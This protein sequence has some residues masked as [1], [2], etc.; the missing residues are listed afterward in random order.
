MDDKVVIIGAGPSGNHAAYLLARK[1]FKVS[2]YENHNSIGR[3]IQ[4]TGILT[5]TIYDVYDVP[6]EVIVN[7]AKS[8]R[9]FSPSGKTVDIKL[10]GDIIVDRHLFDKSIADKAKDAG[11]EFFLDSTFI[12]TAYDSGSKVSK[13]NSNFAV[14][15]TK[16]RKIDA[17]IK[18]PYNY[19]IGADGPNSAVAKSAG[20]FQNRESRR[21]FAGIQ[22]TIKVDSDPSIIEF[23]PYIGQLG[24]I[25]PESPSI[26]R[27]GIAA[28]ASA[29]D[30]KTVYDPR[31]IFED[32]CKSRIGTDWKSKIVEWQSGPIPVYDPKIMIE[33]NNIFTIGDAA[34]QVKATTA[35][36]IIQGMNA[37]ECVSRS[38]ENNE[39][40]TSL[41]NKKIGRELSTSLF[42]RNVFNTFKKEDYDELVSICSN[43]KVKNILST[44]DRDKISGFF[45]KLLLAEPKLI[46]FFNYQSVSEFV[47]LSPRLLF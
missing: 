19:L 47:K 6:K 33:K 28:Y 14:I 40:Y 29:N 32:F 5:S 1:G 11:A 3:P 35:G 43:E 17:K 44:H 39:S 12:G 20:I 7:R 30:L 9:V 34:A 13:A 18:A 22:A 36:G 27:V 10:K 42:V 41:C 4:C 8:T 25:T 46:K 24:W 26:A 31:V 15:K 45:F 37:A 38:I 2:V 16:N 21:F 23:Y